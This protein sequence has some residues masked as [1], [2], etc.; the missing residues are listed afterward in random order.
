MAKKEINIE[1]ALFP[2]S[3]ELIEIDGTYQVQIVDAELD[4]IEGIFDYDGC[5][6]LIV[7]DYDYITLTQDN[8]ILLLDLIERTDRL[9]SKKK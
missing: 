6:K 7:K 5:A 2:Q 9:Y 4:P 8:L 1:K 3:N